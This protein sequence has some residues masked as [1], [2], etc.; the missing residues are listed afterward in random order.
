MAG[1]KFVRTDS[2]AVTIKV[3]PR[4]GKHVLKKSE[5]VWPG[6]A[7]VGKTASFILRGHV[8][9]GS[10]TAGLS[11]KIKLLE[12]P[13]RVTVKSR[14]VYGNPIEDE[15]APGESAVVPAAGYGTYSECTDTAASGELLFSTAGTYR[16]KIWACYTESPQHETCDDESAIEVTTEVKRP[17]TVHKKKAVLSLTV[18]V[19]Q[20]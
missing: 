20:T 11:F 4:K 17:E 2:I 3:L 12:G 13:D 7:E 9:G 14:D 10:L 5:A 19:L 18:T 16:F 15:V 8:E 6:E 1:S